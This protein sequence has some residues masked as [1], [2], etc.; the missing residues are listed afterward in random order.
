MKDVVIPDSHILVSF[1]VKQL[2]TSIPHSLAK[3]CIRNFLIE[4]M[5]IFMETTL[6]EVHII[7]LV[8]LCL[9]SICFSFRKKLYKQISGTPMGSPVSVVVAEIVIQHMERKIFDSNYDFLFWY[10]YVDDILTCIPKNEIKQILLFINSINRNIQFTLEQEENNI[11]NFLDLK[12]IKSSSGHLHFTV[13][14]KP[15]HTDKYL[16]YDSSHPL[17]HKES[18]VKSLLSRKEQLCDVSTKY[19]EESHIYE[20]SKENNYPLSFLDKISKKMK[21][22]RNSNDGASDFDHIVA[23]YIPNVSERISKVLRSVNVK[24]VHKPVN[25]LQ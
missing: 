9:E 19:Q 4:N 18:V 11:I 13:H 21:T 25:K 8:D 10:H 2:F 5:D 14:R 15:T 24:L 23:P 22:T 17:Q 16:S 3:D 12:I 1:D 20:V 7:K 6:D